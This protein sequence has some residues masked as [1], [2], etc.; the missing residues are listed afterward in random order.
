MVIRAPPGQ[1]YDNFKPFKIVRVKCVGL[2]AWSKSWLYRS[3]IGIIPSGTVVV[4]V[5]F[6]GVGGGGGGGESG[7]QLAPRFTLDSS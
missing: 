3:G 1:C 4:F 5:F 2:L 6:M 7:Y